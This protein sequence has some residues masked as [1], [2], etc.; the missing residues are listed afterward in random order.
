[1]FHNIME[2]TQKVFAVFSLFT[3]FGFTTYF[4]CCRKKKFCAC[5]VKKQTNCDLHK[6]DFVSE[7]ENFIDQL[8]VEMIM[9]IFSCL[10]NYYNVSLVNKQF[11]DVA[12]KMNDRNV[13]LT[14]DDK[15]FVSITFSLFS[16]FLF[17]NKNVNSTGKMELS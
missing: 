5:V 16:F 1:M 13:S 9:N 15:F 10:P 3:L 12:C 14:L 8:P 17:Y 11:Y 7:N 2:Q 4:C 6:M